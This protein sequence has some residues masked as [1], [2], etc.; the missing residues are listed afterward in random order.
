MA[1]DSTDMVTACARICAAGF[2]LINSF[3]PGGFAQVAGQTPALQQAEA[4]FQ[5]QDWEHAASAYSALAA[6]D[7]G[8]F[9]LWNR[10]GF[11]FHHEGRYDKAAAA[12]GKAVA[13]NSQSALARYNLA[14]ACARLDRKDEAF[15]HLSA[16]AATGFFLPE[17]IQ[18]DADLANLRGEARFEEILAQAQAQ[19]SARP[20]TA[21]PEF[22]QFDFWIGEWAVQSQATGQP[23]GS[24]SVQLILG[25]CVLFENWSGV[26]GMNGKSFNTYDATRQKWQQTWVDDR[27]GRTDYWGE[28][29]G[30]RMEFLGEKS[31][32]EGGTPLL[33]MTFFKLGPDRVRQLGEFSEDAGKIW[34][35]RYDLLYVRKK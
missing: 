15:T 34:N 26:R 32:T 5:A 30:E 18:Q 3:A 24:S 9:Q 14:C 4:F 1:K 29:H 16:I 33:R 2:L 35:V 21:A 11:A 6:A 28:F 13:L 8:N 20:C 7:P 19:R 31:R 22:R 27:G 17:Q 10:L 25:E 23:A 12:Y